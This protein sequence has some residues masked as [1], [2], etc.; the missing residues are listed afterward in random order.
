[1][2]LKQSIPLKSLRNA[3]ELGGYYTADGRMIKKGVLLRTAKLNGIS[4]EDIRTLEDVYRLQHIIDFRM[5]MELKGDDYP[6]ISGA[7]YSRLDV[8]DFSEMSGGDTPDIDINSLDIIDITKLTL[9]S[10]MLGDD[11]Y[12]GFLMPDYGKK[13][14]SRFF[15]ILLDANPDR[16]V[17][18]HCTS[19]KD[20]TG[21]AAMLLLSALGVDEEAVISDYALTNEYNSARIAR[22]EQYLKAKGCD[23]AFISKALLVF[24]MVDERILRTAINYLKEKYGSVTG[25][26]RGGLNI[27]DEEINSLKEKYLI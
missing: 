20:R 21:L 8:L 23:D 6:K 13:A 24:D 26:I 2:S 12:I 11:M 14:Y 10:G 9:S 18:W 7:E 22:T 5:P 15:R 25:Y 3:R 16:A 17:L 19:G 4:G 27:S 1:M